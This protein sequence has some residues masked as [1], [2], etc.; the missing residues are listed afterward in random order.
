MSNP[1]RSPHPVFVAH[2]L[3]P[4]HLR[5]LVEDTVEAFDNFWLLLP[6]EGEILESGRACLARLQGFAVHRGFA[7]VTVAYAPGR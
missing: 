4:P 3:C 2:P 1:S 6:V 7:V 5:S